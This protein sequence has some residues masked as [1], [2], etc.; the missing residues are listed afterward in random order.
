MNKTSRNLINNK[1][2][3]II[4][5]YDAGEL[6]MRDIGVRDR[7]LEKKA[8]LAN[9]IFRNHLLENGLKVKNYETKD[10]ICV[11]FNFGCHDYEYEKKK[12]EK[13]LATTEHKEFYQSLLEKLEQDKN[14]YVNFTKEQIRTHYYENGI[15]IDNVHYKM[16]YRSAGKAKDGECMFIDSRLYEDSI[17]YLSMGL[18]GKFKEGEPAKIVELASYSPLITSAIE[19]Q[20]YI[21]VD[22]ILILKD[23]ESFKTI[24]AN[25]IELDENKNVVVSKRHTQITNVLF[26][27]E[28]LLDEDFFP[29]DR[30]GF[31]LLRNHMFKA[32]AFNTKIQSYFKDYCKEYGLDYNTYQIKDMFGNM[33]YAKDIKMITTDNACKWLKFKDRMGKNPYNYWKRRVEKDKSLF[34]I[35]KSAH[36]SKYGEKQRLSYQMINSLPLSYDEVKELSEDDIEYVTKLK[37]DDKFFC[38]FLRDKANEINNYEMLSSMWEYNHDFANTDWFKDE[39]KEIINSYVTEL[40]NGKI[41]VYGD[42]LTMVSNP[43]ELLQYA[44]TGGTYKPVFETEEVAIQCYTTRFQ[45]DEFL[46]VFRSPQNSPNNVAYFHNVYRKEF[47][48]L[49]L[50]PNVIIVNSIGTDLQDRLNGCDFDL[51][52]WVA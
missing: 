14:K 13:K 22:D 23:R 15:D 10:I 46:A 36:V 25:I 3:I 28:A 30:E 17:K 4:S 19:D 7:V 45:N 8:V 44:I 29:S 18:W 41:R 50:N 11:T 32:C 40:R 24:K 1:K 35:V 51:T 42:N 31:I 16:L 2:G 26:D 6:Y 38:S 27:G 39:R 20:I 34:G 21:P 47:K 5:T 49:N 33:H 43:I 12:L 37:N 9:S 48:Y 52:T